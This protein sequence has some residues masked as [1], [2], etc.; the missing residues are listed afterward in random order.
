[1]VLLLS[2]SSDKS[3]DLAHRLKKFVLPNGMTCLLVKREGAPVFSGY[4]RLRVGNIEEEVGASGLAHFFEHMAFKGTSQIGTKDFEKEKAILK[5]LHAVG[6]E[7]AQ[8]QRAGG[9]LSH[10]IASLTIELGELQA[11]AQ[12]FVER[13]ELVKI[14]QQNGGSDINATT[15]NDYTSYFVS[16]PSNKLEMWAALESARLMDPVLR[17]F[18]KERDVVAEERRMRFDNSPEGHLYEAFLAESY[19]KSRYGVNVIG[20]AEDI[21]TYTFE[22]AKAF[23]DRYYIPSRMVMA[24]VGNFD[25][26][27]AE[28]WVREYFGKI[29]AKENPPDN[30]PAE[31]LST[32]YPRQKTIEFN[33]EPRFYLGYHRPAYPHADDE[34]LDVIEQLMC[35]GRTSRLYADLVTDKKLASAVDCYASIPGSRLDGMF[36]FF[37]VPLAPATNAD[38]IGELKLQIENLKT[39]PVSAEE[40]EKVRAQVKADLVRGLKSN[41]GLASMLTYFQSLTGDWRYLYQL[42]E[43]IKKISAED[44]MRVAQT[45]FVPGREVAVFMEK[46]K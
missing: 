30:F 40:L 6:T 21:Q 35:E 31:D 23:R 15:S 24:V 12:E 11:K 39:K 46:G 8:K 41:M 43:H 14:Y 2:C 13:N 17:E 44:I 33:A 5:E 27:Q 28:K 29:P 25:V 34:V 45:Y 16:L 7:L 32:G 37:A 9:A 18:Y 26:D 36:A 20:F 10:E 3:S 4:I 1:M 38:V 19:Q 22:E 42:Q